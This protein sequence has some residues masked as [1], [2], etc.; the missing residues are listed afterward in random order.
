MT[1]P[2]ITAAV[3]AKEAVDSAF[4]GFDACGRWRTCE[5]D[6]HVLASTLQEEC[7]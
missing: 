5:Y 4:V 7:S 3:V 2:S 6:F 1:L